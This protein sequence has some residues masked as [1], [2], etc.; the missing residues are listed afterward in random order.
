M[1]GIDPG[2]AGLVGPVLLLDDLGAITFRR[3]AHASANSRS[4]S[5]RPTTRN[6]SVQRLTTRNCARPSASMAR[7]GMVCSTLARQVILAQPVI[8]GAG[9]EQSMS[10]ASPDDRRWSADPSAG[11]STTTHRTPSATTSSKAAER[12]V[13]LRERRIRAARKSW[14]MN[15]PVEMLSASASRAPCTPHRSGSDPGTTTGSAALPPG[16]GSRSRQ[17]ALSPPACAEGIA[18]HAAANANSARE[19]RGTQPI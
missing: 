12:S 9:V 16:S 13:V 2:I 6:Q 5:W 17:S 7:L 18:G 1:A 11:K 8:P 4:A 14:P 15:R 3:P 10:A 19:R